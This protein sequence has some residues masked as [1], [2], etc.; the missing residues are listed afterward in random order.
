M[1]FSDTLL[2]F[3]GVAAIDVFMETLW[4]RGE[5]VHEMNLF[6][7]VGPFK[8]KMMLIKALIRNTPQFS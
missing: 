3:C 2:A 6:H 7:T 5:I 1:C 4:K 8:H